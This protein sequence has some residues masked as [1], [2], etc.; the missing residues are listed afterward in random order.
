MVKSMAKSIFI[1]RERDVWATLQRHQGMVLR[2]N[3]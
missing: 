3:E 2:A 1:H